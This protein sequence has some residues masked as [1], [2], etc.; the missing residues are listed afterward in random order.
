MRH[1][2]ASHIFHRALKKVLGA[3]AKQMSAAVSPEKLRFDC[4]LPADGSLEQMKV[5]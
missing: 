2:T 1:H 4:L 5:T 3:D